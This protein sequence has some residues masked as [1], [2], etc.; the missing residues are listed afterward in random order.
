MKKR[1][2]GILSFCI[3]ILAGFL[4]LNIMVWRDSTREVVVRINEHEAHTEQ[5][6]L[7]VTVPKAW[8][9]TDTNGKECLGVQY[10][11]EIENKY[12][13]AFTNWK[14]YIT[15]PEHAELDSY[16]NGLYI[17]D[18]E[19][20]C[21]IP[22]TD[23]DVH[24]V[25][26]GTKE[27]F[28]FVLK[29][30]MVLDIR[31]FEII[32]HWDAKL[33]DYNLF[34]IWLVVLIIGVSVIAWE[35]S[36]EYKTKRLRERQKNDEKIILETMQTIANFVDAKD[37]YTKGH[38]LRVAE[39]SM[40]IAEKMNMSKDEIRNIGYIGLMHDCGKM[41][42]ADYVLTKPGKLTEDEFRIIRMHTI[43]GGEILKSMTAI[44]GLRDGAYYHHER[45]DGKGYPEGLKGEEI[46]LCARIIGV[47]DSFD[48]MN[49][50]RCYRKHLSMEAIIEEL[51]TNMGKQFDPDIAKHMIQMLENNELECEVQNIIDTI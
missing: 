21:F 19:K 50:D 11:F 28:G 40:K 32:G 46:P 9:D 30:E 22:S 48:A 34:Y 44:K 7:T 42:V 25:K 27:G 1:S 14:L 8:W 15:L 31:E 43:Y 33:T 12:S 41:G 17:P 10:D 35:W 13:M 36:L 18:G 39:Y 6:N 47:A 26:A 37:P 5:L 24:Y 2:I 4:I 3:C 16:W 49:A 29:S 23:R 20:I 38:S 51:R 45:Y